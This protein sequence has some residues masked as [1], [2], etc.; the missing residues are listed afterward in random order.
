MHQKQSTMYNTNINCTIDKIEKNL[1]RAT[2][3]YVASCMPRAC[4]TEKLGNIIIGFSPRNIKGSA[5]GGRIL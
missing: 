2:Y 4:N 5:V 3:M 1:R